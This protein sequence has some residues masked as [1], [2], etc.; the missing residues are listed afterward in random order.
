MRTIRLGTFHGRKEEL[1]RLRLEHE[2]PGF[3]LV[4]ITGRRRIGKTSLLLEFA[5]RTKGPYLYFEAQRAPY[6]ANLQLLAE[7]AY[8]FAQQHGISSVRLPGG[9]SPTPQA[10]GGLLQDLMAWFESRGH[11]LLIV[12]DEFPR[13]CRPFTNWDR[14]MAPFDSVLQTLI[15]TDWNRR[16][17]TVVLC[18]SSASFMH[19]LLVSRDA[20]LFGRASWTLFLKGLPFEETADMLGLNLDQRSD[21]ETA[22]GLYSTVGGTP[23]YLDLIRRQRPDES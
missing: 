20:P 22:A 1:K 7:E 23:Y 3:S 10:V 19:R 4:S 18:G 8:A 6:L 13:L 5:R 16:N 21:R 11:K 12:F 17:C 9:V 15:D 2:A 14:T